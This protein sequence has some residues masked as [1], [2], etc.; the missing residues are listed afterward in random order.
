MERNELK[1]GL[2]LFS[3]LILICCTQMN[4][5][6]SEPEQWEETIREFEEQDKIHPPEDGAVL[7]TGSSSIAM[8][9]DIEEYFPAHKVINRGFGGSE[10]SDL[11]YYADRVIYPY[12]PSQIFIYEG[13]NDI[14]SGKSVESILKEAKQLREEI[15]K[16]LPDTKVIFISPKPSL[17]RWELKETYEEFNR[18]LE[19]YTN[20]T[21]STEFADVWSPM[22]DQN[23]KVLPDLFIEDGLHMNSKGYDIWQQVLAPYMAEP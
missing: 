20:E 14:A 21:E 12:Q 8:W 22:L 6:G 9:E 11:L 3:L 18:K 2:P 7:F 16:E 1:N 17:S 19:E 23:G 13:D 10:F 4:A 5:Q 15:K